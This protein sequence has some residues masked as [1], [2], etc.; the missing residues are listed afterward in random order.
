MYIKSEVAN[1]HHRSNFELE[2]SC[3]KNF[4]NAL[5]KKVIRVLFNEKKL[6]VFHDLAQ[7]K[8]RARL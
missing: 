7:T 6:K 2:K 4:G 8:M 1:I 3:K 5:K